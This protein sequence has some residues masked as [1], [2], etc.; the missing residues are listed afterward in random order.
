MSEQPESNTT[1]IAAY[2]YAIASA[3]ERRDIDP[4]DV[5]SRAG[6][7]LSSKTDPMVR[8]GSAEISRLF[9][10]AVEE[11][12]DPAFGLFVGD[13]LHPGNLHALGYALMSSDSLRDYCNRLVNYYRLISMGAGIRVEETDSDLLL[14][15]EVMSDVC[16]ETQDAFVALHV[17]I[18][19][20]IYKPN[21]N[22]AWLNL[23]RPVPECGSQ[24]YDN[25][26][27]CQISFSESQ[28][29]IAIDRTLVD[30]PLAGASKELAQMHDLTAGQYIDKLDKSD[31]VNRVHTVIV[32]GL[33]AGIVT[34]K[35]VAEKLNMSPR[36]LQLKLS[37]RDV[38]FQRLLDETRKSLALGYIERS[39]IAITE[40]AYLLGF[41]DVSNFT[42]AFRRWT[43]KSPSAYRQSL[44][45]EL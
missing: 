1:T 36:N 19:R 30:E 27:N 26:F 12:R 5:F 10:L 15:T 25:Y 7:H 21:F 42:R 9:A 20:F 31:I 8:L 43:D 45:G 37:A 17:R 2:G 22:P 34:R 4:S 33:S 29:V 44:E 23:K 40:I 28:I 13:C 6:V 38:S 14:I 11:T 24:P 39:S 41:S 18:M 35:W 32:E 16:H 3:L